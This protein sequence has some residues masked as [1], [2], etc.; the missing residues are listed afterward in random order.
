M[1]RKQDLFSPISPG[2]AHWEPHSYM[3]ESH[4]K[5]GKDPLDHPAQPAANEGH[6]CFSFPRAGGTPLQQGTDCFA[7][8]RFNLPLWGCWGG[9]KANSLA[10]QIHTHSGPWKDVQRTSALNS[11]RNTPSCGE[12]AINPWEIKISL[13]VEIV[14]SPNS[15]KF[16]IWR[17]VKRFP[18]WNDV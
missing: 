4:V 10:S 2:L 15:A 14:P 7:F 8:L 18:K 11:E 3:Y 16:W 12:M 13:G 1:E 9:S 17:L 5:H 6:G